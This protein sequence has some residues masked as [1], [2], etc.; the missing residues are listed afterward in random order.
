MVFARRA[1]ALKEARER[2]PKKRD[3]NPPDPEEAVE[4]E[5]TDSVAEL[6]PPEG[7][8]G[9]VGTSPYFGGGPVFFEPQFLCHWCGEKKGVGELVGRC[10]KC[11][12]M[13]CDECVE[14]KGR[15]IYCSDHAPRCFI[16]TA[17]YQS[18]E[19][20]EVLYLRKFR[21]EFL[22]RSSIGTGF[23]DLYYSTSPQVARLIERHSGLR[24]AF[25]VILGPGVSLGRILA[26][27]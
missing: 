9:G 3:K 14:Y 21:D 16:A 6:F 19:A 22:L 25:R 10:V 2:M 11:S 7:S 27:S 20:P 18:E 17:T 12:K 26:R 13:L 24:Q 8:L 1:F 4:E 5:E 15:R 23:V